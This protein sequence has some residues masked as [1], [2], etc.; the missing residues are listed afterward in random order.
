MEKENDVKFTGLLRDKN[1]L[2]FTLVVT[3]LTIVISTLVS[4]LVGVLIITSLVL[5]LVV[6]FIIFKDGKRVPNL[7]AVFTG[8]EH[9]SSGTELPRSCSVCGGER[10]QRQH[11][12]L[13][14]PITAHSHAHVN[15]MVPQGVDEALEELLNLTLD[16][17][18][19]VWYREISVHDQL[20]DE[21]RFIIRYAVA[22]IS[23]RLSKVDLTIVIIDH[24]LPAL[25]NH[26]DAY[27]EG[28]RR[29]R[30][31]IS[32]EAAVIQYLR[33]GS[34][35]HQAVRSREEEAAY[36]RAVVGTVLPFVVPS[37]YLSSS[38]AK[39]FLEELLGR[40]LLLQLMDLLANPDTLNLLF[41]LLLSRDSSPWLPH[42]PEPEVLLLKNFASV[43]THPRNSV[44][45]CNLSSVLKDQS[46]LYLF[47][48]FLKEEGA[49]NILQF[50]LAVEDFNHH[51]LDPDL[52]SEQLEQLHHE[53]LELYHTYMVTTAVD[54]I[55]FPH[56]VVSHIRE[57]VH[58]DIKD[59]VKLRTTR[60]LFQAYEHAYNLLEREYLPL[61]MHSHAS[62]ERSVRIG[63]HVALEEELS[64]RIGH[65]V[66][67]E[68]G[69]EPSLSSF[70]PALL[71][72]VL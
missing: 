44:L 11:P 68:E 56:H 38:V 53:A 60:P 65:H 54:R 12:A 19:Y 24:L 57:I 42:K 1:I 63:H 37:K 31:N 9:P 66:P 10:C 13:A 51:I 41:L 71:C 18:V 67:L 17:Y 47:H 7:L 4:V 26:L 49:I 5:G 46:L 33:A 39:S 27:V 14:H 40:V 30:G 45:R 59:I 15:F 69:E 36:L 35:L 3:L 70:P 62:V 43:N 8:H 32:T 23:S 25:I 28:S 50:C 6:P 21:I 64:V 72:L 34:G 29:V 16:H 48:T 2:V 58:S 52:T 20:A 55:N 61:F 22:N